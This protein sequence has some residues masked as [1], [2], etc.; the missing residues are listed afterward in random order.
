MILSLGVM[1]WQ[2]RSLRAGA[3]RGLGSVYNLADFATVVQRKL[4]RA[5]FSYLGALL[6]LTVAVR[7]LAYARGVPVPTCW[8]WPVRA[9]LSLSSWPWW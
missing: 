9:S 5:T 2:V 8:F 7:A 1:E 3:R 4:A 6:L